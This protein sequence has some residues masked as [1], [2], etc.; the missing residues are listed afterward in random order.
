[1]MKKYRTIV[2]IVLVVLMVASVY[3]L[4]SNGI[5]QKQELE[6]ILNK[7]QSCQEQGLYEKATDYYG[8]AIQLE[9][10]LEYY[11][12][13]A[14]M[15]FDIEKYDYCKKWC[16]E[17][18]VKF[19][20][21]SRPYE[22]M[23]AVCLAEERFSEAYE[24]LENF[25]GRGLVSDVME[26][27]RSK[28]EFLY[29]TEYVAHEQV[30]Y[31]GTEYVAVG[32]DEVWGLA[33][34]KGAVSIV[35]KLEKVGYFANNMVAVCDTEGIWYFMNANGEYLY[36]LS[37]AIDGEITEVGVYNED[38]FPVCVNGKYCYYDLNLEKKLGEYDYAGAFHEGVAAVKRGDSWQIINTEGEPINKET[39]GDIILDERGVCCQ[40]ERIFVKKQ[41][42][43]ILIDKEGKQ[44]GT[45]CFEE[46]KLFA[47]D[48]Y[49]AVMQDEM[50]GYVS[51]SGEMLIEPRYQDAK[52]F[53]L[54]L[55]AVCEDEKWG[56]IDI[57]GNM[58]YEE[59]YAECLSFSKYGTAYVKNEQGWKLI[60]LY[61]YNH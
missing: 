9:D 13:V 57:D 44:I 38:F 2:P 60:K 58:I 24:T 15:Y 42:G 35:P 31:S 27:Y 28:M 59:E 41:E 29:Y 22:R 40:S 19:P 43:Y 7:A 23:V 4:I 45:E 16:E 36:N 48:D 53:S 10:K 1:M 17:A 26:K 20:N 47:G 3:S 6:K 11:L 34:V 18:L 32:D 46:A 12:V 50:W 37:N 52:S 33:T 8:E 55:A 54:K 49:A 51:T 5:S 61:K 39:Y 25:D 21:E 30:R 56:Y 14:D